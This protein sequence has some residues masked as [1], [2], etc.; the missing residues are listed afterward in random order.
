[1]HVPFL[2]LHAQHQS[3]QPQLNETIQKVIEESAFIKGEGVQSFEASLSKYLGVEHSISCGN[4]TDALELVLDALNIG[5]GD[6]V[7]VPA[8]SWI[9]TSEVVA[10]R[11]AKPVF[12][13]THP[14]SNCIDP[15]KL[16]EKPSENTKALIAV[17]LYGH[18]AAMDLLSD[19]CQKHQLFLI[20]DAAQALGGKWQGQPLGSLATAATFSFFPSKNLGCMGDGGAIATNTRGLA[21]KCRKL[22]NHGQSQRHHFELDGRNS[23]LDNLQAAILNLK[24]PHLNRWVQ[25]RTKLALRYSEKLAHLGG[26]ELPHLC[27]GHAL[28]LYVIKTG[29]RNELKNFL[30]ENG[31]QT[32]VHYPAPLPLAE[33]YSEMGHSPEDFPIAVQTCKEALSLP[34]YPELTL[35][36]QD[37]VIEK[38]ET[39]FK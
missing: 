32:L 33:C 34:L 28:H 24:L 6:E 16:P 39:F 31:I 20:E 12:I 25:T 17:H 14:E 11:G 8:L 38:I 5:K 37:Y 27:E 36:Q 23:R 29:R 7:L 19:Y 13:D 22:A 1:M 15:R 2:D 4:G 30:D 18:P 10:T 3:L 26:L 35:P 9:S 21:E